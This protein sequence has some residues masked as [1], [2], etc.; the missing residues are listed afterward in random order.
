MD[1]ENAAAAFIR[2]LARYSL[3]EKQMETPPYQIG[4]SVF[5]VYASAYSQVEVDCCVCYGKRVVRVE[6]GNGELVTVACEGCSH[7]VL[8]PTGKATAYKAVSGIQEVTVTGLQYDNGEWRV[9]LSNGESLNIAKSENKR[10]C[11]NRQT[12]ETMEAILLP[13]VQKQ[14]EKMFEYS[15]MNAKKKSV[16]TVGYHRAAITRLRRELAFYEGKLK[17]ETGASVGR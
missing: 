4:Q 9:S 14:A 2:K 13:V 16:S 11:H 10:I 3:K 5:Y 6:L 15:M 17:D 1:T 8:A 12:A 7:G